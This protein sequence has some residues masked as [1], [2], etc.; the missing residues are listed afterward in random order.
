MQAYRLYTLAQA[1]AP[2]MGA[3]N[4]LR[5]Q[6]NLSATAVWMLAA[7]YAKAGQPEAAKKLVSNLSTTIKAYRELGYSYG[8][9]VRDRALI[10]ETLILL[11]DKTKA[12]E[13]LKEIS[14]YLS[15]DGYWLSTQETA[16]CLK[17]VGAFAG[18]EKRGDLK[19]SYTLNGK[20]VNA[21]TELP[22][23][24]VQIP[25]AGLKK[26]SVK[27]V[28]ESSGML[29]TRIIMEG[30]P[31]RGAEE[32]A[33]SNLDMTVRYTDTKGA[34]VDI[35]TLEQG[36]EFVAEVTVAHTGIRSTYENLA[37]SQVFPSGWE[38]NNLRL[39][40]DEEFLKSSPFDYQDIRD[41][42]V[43]TYFSLYP[44]ERRTFRVMLTASY[45]GAF[46]LPATTCEAMYDKSIYV[47]KKGQVVNVTKPVV[48]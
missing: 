7:S 13:K 30:T 10:L 2:E 20:T 25:I 9:D 44:N 48:Q 23:A 36:S 37:L 47:R 42:R 6:G 33:T 35:T 19:F 22:M 4:R 28:N 29:F 18:I 27:I 15:N 3:M 11:G 43:Y 39:Q 12:F 26:E 24:Q 8:S 40:G 46:Y 5:E 41:D 1:G 34:N 14:K 45:A 32:D 17:A 31:A 21:S 38:I 16:F